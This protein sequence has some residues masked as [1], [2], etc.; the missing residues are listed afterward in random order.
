MGIRDVLR[1]KRGSA[2]RP[3]KFLLLSYFC[4]P[5]LFPAM[6]LPYNVAQDGPSLSYLALIPSSFHE[7]VFREEE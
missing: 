7:V 5:A 2:T 1:F 3:S 4:V 6:Q